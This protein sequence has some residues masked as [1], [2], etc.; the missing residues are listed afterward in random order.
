MLREA[1]RV[2]HPRA[3]AVAVPTL[4]ALLVCFL[5]TNNAC[6]DV[7]IGGGTAGSLDGSALISTGAAAFIDADLPALYGGAATHDGNLPAA[8]RL[9]RWRMPRAGG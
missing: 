3:A 4:Q 9:V 6:I 7:S 1:P 8:L 5:P 2:A